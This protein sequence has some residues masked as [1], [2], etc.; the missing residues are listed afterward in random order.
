MAK[1]TKEQIKELA[2]MGVMVNEKG[3]NLSTKETRLEKIIRIKSEK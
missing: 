3:E 2:K 1:Y